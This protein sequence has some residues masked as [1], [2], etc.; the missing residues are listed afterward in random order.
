MALLRNNP[1]SETAFNE[2]RQLSD[3]SYK[4]HE[5]Q[6][7]R[8]YVTALTGWMQ[9][10]VE[11]K[12][13]VAGQYLLGD[14][15]PKWLSAALQLL[16]PSQALI[17]ITAKEIPKDVNASFD[18]KEK[19]YGTPYHVEKLPE[20][21]I[22]D[23]MAG[24]PIPDLHLPGPNPFV[25][26]RLD[27]VKKDVTDPAERPELLSDSEVSRLWFKQDDRFWVP[28][29]NV[30]VEA[31]SP[32]LE[33]SPRTAVLARLLCDLYNDA[34]V[35]DV[36]DAELAE[37]GF[38][39]WYGGDS[40]NVAVTGFTDKQALLLETML[41]KL[42]NF[43]VDP[44]RFDKVV[45]QIKLHWKN[46]ELSEPYHVAMYWH[47]YV[48][49]QVVW[50]QK[51]KLAEIEHITPADVQAYAR[52]LFQRLYFE[53]LV[54]GNTTA[55]EAKSIQEAVEKVLHPRALVPAEKI[56]RRALQLPESK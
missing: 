26:E 6:K 38:H 3:I 40:L 7:V 48:S 2:I 5:R 35:E 22:A 44:E 13:I 24:A 21:F 27:V 28:K 42:V 46:F 49:T 31:H 32:L 10:P 9:S 37:L 8:N 55:A 18:K 12:D 17:G 20:E 34:I 52:E 11:R 45:D 53:T 33:A 30:Y 19:I 50:T 4:F 36:Y 51:E 15:D 16:D 47:S 43:E 39:L 29:T 1:P 41:Q 25:P 23:A 14:F 56:P 54:H